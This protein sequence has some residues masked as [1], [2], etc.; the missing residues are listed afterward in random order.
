MKGRFIDSISKWTYADLKADL[1]RNHVPHS[2]NKHGMAQRL[3]SF[4]RQQF[5]SQLSPVEPA[6][7]ASNAASAQSST[8]SE[9]NNANNIPTSS[10]QDVTPGRP[11]PDSSEGLQ[12]S[13]SRRRLP[14][15][16]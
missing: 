4:Y 16:Y 14:T 15:T 1:I 3:Q 5:G 10:Q 11:A 6:S 13:T 9:Q 2:G 7:D 8:N 12:S